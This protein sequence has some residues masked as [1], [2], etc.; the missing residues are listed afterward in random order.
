[1][2]LGWGQAAGFLGK[3]FDRLS[4]PVRKAE[5]LEDEKKELL[6]KRLND[7]AARR[8]ADIDRDLKRLRKEIDRRAS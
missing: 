7:R 5:K 4:D 1:M 3:L 8:L 2:S 6:S